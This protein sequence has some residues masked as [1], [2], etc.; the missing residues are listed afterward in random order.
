[1]YG[2]TKEIILKSENG[3]W[4]P[5]NIII[6]PNQVNSNLLYAAV[7]SFFTG[8]FNLGGT[9]AEPVT[10]MLFTELGSGDN[11]WGK[12][13]SDDE[14]G[15]EIIDGGEGT[16]DE[17]TFASYYF[18]ESPVTISSL[19]LGYNQVADALETVYAT[20]EPDTPLDANTKYIVE[21]TIGFPES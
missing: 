5:K 20:Q 14:P 12:K 3:L 15:I 19:Q 16:T 7:R 13:L 17:I 21:W 1:M 10:D 9:D 4:V 11:I 2:Y 8:Y 18:A 6:K